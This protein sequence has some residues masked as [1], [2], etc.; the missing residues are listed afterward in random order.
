M[1][2]VSAVRYAIVRSK[3]YSILH[4][5]VGDVVGLY[6]ISSFHAAYD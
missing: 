4:N 6:V 2:T 1:F 5:F 3:T